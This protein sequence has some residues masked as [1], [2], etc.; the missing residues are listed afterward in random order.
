MSDAS[1]QYQKYITGA[2]EG[3]VYNV[4]GVK[5]DGYKDGVL[6]EAKGIYSNFVNKSGE[7]YE[8]F[9]GSEGLV[10]QARRQ[11]AAADGMAVKWFFNDVVSLEATK[12]LLLKEGISGIEL[13]LN[14]MP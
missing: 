10:N 7:F 5:F 6:L 13:V 9:T 11:I 12:K 8:W 3:M 2:D 1:R 4:N 14:I